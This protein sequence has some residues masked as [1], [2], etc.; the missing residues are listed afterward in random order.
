[1]P[2]IYSAQEEQN[3]RDVGQSIPHT[4][5]TLD[6]KQEDHHETVIKMD[7]KLCDQV[8]SVLIDLGSNYSYV[9]PDLVDKCG[10]KK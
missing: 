1:M 3:I 9:T 7:Y 5:A 2:H 6:N 8:V 4:Y 10:L